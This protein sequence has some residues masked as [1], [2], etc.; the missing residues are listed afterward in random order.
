MSVQDTANWALA[1]STEQLSRDIHTATLL[2][3]LDDLLYAAFEPLYKETTFFRRLLMQV[4]LYATEDNRRRIS[5]IEKE[6]MN[7][8]LL[9]AV[10]NS[11]FDF[12]T[13]AKLDRGVYVDLISQSLEVLEPIE[14]IE[15]GLL[16][17]N[18]LGFLEQRRKLA[19]LFG[20]DQD[21]L[22]SLYQWVN[23]YLKLYLKFKE[24]IVSRYYR[25]AYHEANRI[26]HTQSKRI[27]TKDLFKN[28]V[29]STWKAVDRCDASLGTLTSFIQRSFLNAKTY[30]EFP[31]IY[32]VAYDVPMS[33]RH[34]LKKKNLVAENQSI[35]FDDPIV[36]DSVESTNTLETDYSAVDKNLL[37]FLR[38]VPG[39]EI[40]LL[41]LGV[42]IHLSDKEIERLKGISYA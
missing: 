26:Y 12:F 3:V 5:L 36:S 34:L 14:Q 15:K 28:L 40:G 16:G 19:L 7:S 31:H 35:S 17:K 2:S 1:S 18:K 4:I 20:V 37:A 6:K 27:D 42:P 9:K 38:S 8:W 24:M 32:H 21:R 39:I 11:D 41:M 25:L 22:Y 13:M 30:P 29:L 33:A 10:Y 23:S